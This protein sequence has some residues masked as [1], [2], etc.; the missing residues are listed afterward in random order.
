MVFQNVTHFHE[1]VLLKLMFVH[2]NRPNGSRYANTENQH[3]TKLSWQ[4]NVDNA[5]FSV[6]TRL[7]HDFP[8]ERTYFQ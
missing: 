3:W 5:K 2:F 1:L 6:K 7:D 4:N 8:I